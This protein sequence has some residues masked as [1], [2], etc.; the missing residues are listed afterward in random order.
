MKKLT[1][2][3]KVAYGYAKVYSYD[4]YRFV[5]F[6]GTL[7]T[8][9]HPA[10][11]GALMTKYY[12]MVE[13]GL[14]LPQPRPG[15]G[16]EMTRDLGDQ[17]ERAMRDGICAHEVQLSADALD[18][19]MAFNA[20][21][22]TPSPSH[23]TQSVVSAR[24]AGFAPSGSALK[25][26]KVRQ[27]DSEIHLAF[28][29]SRSSVRGFG[30]GAVP[31]EVLLKAA[32]AAQFAP[33]VCNRQAGRLYFLTTEEQKRKALSYQKGNRGFGD[34]AAVIAIVTVD[35]AE[36]LEPTERYQHWIDGG[37]FAQNFL[38]GIHAQGY[39]A[40]PL[41]W[42]APITR[43]IGIRKL[44]YIP[45]SESIIMMVAIGP[46]KDEYS[47]ARSERR[48]LADIAHFPDLEHKQ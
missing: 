25:H 13:K 44:G 22:G 35:I 29:R 23:V 47:V 42:S 15:F 20:E 46:L 37:L 7:R 30:D 8:R 38:L 33:C 16:A 24:N 18:T 14:A 43:D 11:R 28:L 2:F 19:Y 32:Q 45:D 17:M 10:T 39:G 48:P 3:I 5:R 12:H 1:E 34:T 36:M 26:M 9:T 4:I 27:Q 6:S 21:M 31:Q 40:C 41:N